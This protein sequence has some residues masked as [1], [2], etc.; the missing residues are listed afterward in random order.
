MKIGP[1]NVVAF[2][3]GIGATLGLYVFL[4]AQHLEM[5]G[6]YKERFKDDPDLYRL[7]VGNNFDWLVHL[8]TTIFA[9][10]AISLVLTLVYFAF[11]R[12][13][14]FAVRLVSLVLI[15]LTASFPWFAILLIV[16]GG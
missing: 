3:F 4:A 12:K 9:P 10:A 8:L 7:Y 5:R 6:D 16:L 11:I 1:G 14:R 13:W 15:V 2:L